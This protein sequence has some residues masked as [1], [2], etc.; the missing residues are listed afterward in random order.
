MPPDMPAAKL[1]PVA[2]S[3]RHGAA[4]HVFAAVVADALDHRV[5]AGV[6]HREALARDAAEVRLARDRA[7]EH[8]VAGD[9]VLGRLAAELGRGLHRDAPARQAFAAVVVGVADQVERHALRQERAEALA[10]RAGKADVDRVI[11]QA[12]VAVALRDLARQHGA[13]RAVDV[14][15]R[16]VDRDLFAALERGL[17][18][19]DQPVVERLLQAVVLLLAVLARDFG[20]DRRL[21]ED[22]REVQALRLPVLDALLRVEQVGAAD[23]LVELAHAEARHHLAHLFGDEEEV[24]DDVLGLALEFPA[25]HR[26]L[27]R[28]AHRAGVEV[29][30]AHHDAA[31]DDQR[32]GG[33]AELVGA[34]QRADDDVAPGLHLAVDLHGDAAAQA[35]EHQRLLRFGEA[36]LPGRAGVLD[37]RP[38]ARRRCRRRGRRS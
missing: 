8:D 38:G 37:R 30:F 22:P 32:R 23:Q 17:R 14:A 36:Q 12:L 16:H 33:E 20:P 25:Q 29:A 2:P 26:V 3:T 28:D 1:R 21:M 15:D 31:L 9:D 4:G 11:G 34:E 10:G 27:G 18:E 6:A 24:V 5:R 35:V 19:L 13:D 7:V